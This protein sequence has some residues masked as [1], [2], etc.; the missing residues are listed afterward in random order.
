MVRAYFNT[1]GGVGQLVPARLSQQKSRIH[2]QNGTFSL[3]KDREE[4]SFVYSSFFLVEGDAFAG[5][6]EVLRKCTHCESTIVK[7]FVSL[8]NLLRRASV[9]RNFKYSAWLARLLYAPF[10]PDLSQV[11]RMTSRKLVFVLYAG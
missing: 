4:T 1:H 11:L 9:G 2:R 8:P 7:M 6:T 5:F 10:V 3:V